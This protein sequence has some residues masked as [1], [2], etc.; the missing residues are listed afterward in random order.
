VQ[1][2]ARQLCHARSISED[3][4][5]ILLRTNNDRWLLPARIGLCQVRRNRRAFTGH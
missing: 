1:N 5:L 3:R 2:G 4:A